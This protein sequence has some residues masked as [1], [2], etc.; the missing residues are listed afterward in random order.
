M[1]EGRRYQIVEATVKDTSFFSYAY[2]GE[3]LVLI[4]NP[5]HP[6][7]RDLYKPLAE[8]DLPRDRLL[9]SRLEL[10]LIAAARSDRSRYVR[11][12]SLSRRWP[13]TLRRL[14]ER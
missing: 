12:H 1:R 4:L 3:Q 8:S 6:F 13:P 14:L 5:D 10:L 11:E 2:D 9:R 7:H